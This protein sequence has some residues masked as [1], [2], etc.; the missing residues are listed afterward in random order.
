MSL[1]SLLT[2]GSLCQPHSLSRGGISGFPLPQV[3]LHGILQDPCWLTHAVQWQSLKKIICFP[4]IFIHYWHI[5]SASPE[6]RW[7]N[8]RANILNFSGTF[9]WEQLLDLSLKYSIQRW[10]RGLLKAK[11]CQMMVGGH[12]QHCGAISYTSQKAKSQE[13]KHMHKLIL[14]RDRTKLPIWGAQPSI[15][16][17]TKIIT[18]PSNDRHRAWDFCTS[19]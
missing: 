12:E 9:A 7:G 3:H 11:W 1:L 10:F 6:Y 4:I 8:W 13:W 18:T 15:S 2:W 14:Y 17:S 5:S 16:V 19:L